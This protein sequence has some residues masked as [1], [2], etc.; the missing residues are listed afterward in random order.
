MILIKLCKRV[1]PGSPSV[2]CT[3]DGNPAIAIVSHERQPSDELSW[4]SDSSVSS[5][6]DGSEAEFED[7]MDSTTELQERF[8]EINQVISC[9]YRFSIAIR[10]PT[11]RDRLQKYAAI[12]VSHYEFFDIQHTSH[13][14]PKAEKYLI[15]RLGKA[16]SRRRQLLKY[17]E[18]HHK[19]LAQYIDLPPTRPW[20][21]PEVS[22]PNNNEATNG[23]R[24]FLDENYQ[25]LQDRPDP[26]KGPATIATTINTQT[27]ISTYVGPSNIIAVLSDDGQSQTSYATSVTVDTASKLRVPPPKHD[28]AF[29]GKPFECPY[30]FSITVLRDSRSW[31]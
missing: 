7:G 11:P 9:L 26:R 25:A 24:G 6:A 16:N 5:L 23:G 18:K 27:T 14:F 29:D 10:N 8:L 19:K 12:E 28:S 17:H 3:A 2:A 1:R 20:D 13:K 31:M 22:R 21:T 4:S 15:D 30:C